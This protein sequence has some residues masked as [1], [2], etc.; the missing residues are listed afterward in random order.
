MTN[1]KGAAV[2]VRAEENTWLRQAVMAIFVLTTVLLLALPSLV[3]AQEYNFD[4][5]KVEGN[6]RIESAAILNYAGIEKGKVVTA[7]Q[8]NGAYQRILDSGLF[9]TVDVT[10]RGSRLEI[11][12]VEYPTINRISFEGNAR[13]KDDALASLL[14]SQPRRVLNPNVAERDAARIAEAYSQSGR[15]AARVTPRIIRR[16]DNRADLVFEVFEGGITEVERIGFVGNQ[17]YSDRRLRRV[18]ESKQAGLLRLLIKTDTY[19]A[20]RVEF[21]KQVLRDF[22]LSRGYVD[23]RTTGVNA[24]LSR[25][26]DGYFL[27]FNVQEGQQFKFGEITVNSEID[28]IDSAEYLDALRIKPGVVY[29]PLL[30]E[31]SIARLERLALRDGHDF[32][33]VDPRVTRDERN[34]TLNVEFAV[35]RGPRIFVERIDVEGNTTTLDRVIRHQFHIVE[36]DSFNPREIRESAERIR[37][38][39]F[40][41]T[42]EVNAREGSSPDQVVVDVDVVEKPTGSLKFGGTYSAD[43][44]I[45]VVIDFAEKNFLGRG[46]YLSL[47]V[48]TSSELSDSSFTFIEPAFLG[49]DLSA[50]IVLRYVE[51]DPD[52]ARWTTN[53]GEFR[54][55]LVFPVSEYGRMQVRYTGKNNKMNVDPSLSIPGSLIDAEAA[56]DDVWQSSIGYSYTYDTRNVG[57]D[58][59]RGVLLEF[60]Q[61]FG[62]LGGDYEFIAS[63]AKVVGEMTVLQEEVSLSATFEGGA[64]YSPNKDSRVTDRYFLS[65]KQMRGFEP[66]GIGPREY[67]AGGVQDDA[68]GGNYF[69]VARFEAKFPLGLPEEYGLNAG[70]FYD[71]GTVWGLDQSS[72]NVLYDDLSWRHVIGIA[73][74]WDTPIGPLRFNFTKALKKEDFDIER[75]FDFTIS[76]EF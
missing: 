48:S 20:D 7:G 30:V 4:S 75:S 23:Y 69:A 41:E 28:A 66:L 47:A 8:L 32:V 6:Q 71:V 44:G 12:V 3:N 42:A 57:L 5:V 35:V 50:G 64:L 27:T 39:G 52:D 29:S 72:A 11:K 19:V 55:S 63:T 46:Q 65:S 10:P 18:L 68:L 58:T 62:G 14:E 25:E 1:Y 15:L 24:E 37:V 53:V 49:R 60:N 70:L 76:A 74:F 40:F 59:T 16:S 2:Q 73:F 43:Y 67:Q 17:K 26:R 36:G 51:R 9:E 54:P 34:L 13:L 38:L 45:G 33:R 22:Y 31:N 21:D 61:D 56:R